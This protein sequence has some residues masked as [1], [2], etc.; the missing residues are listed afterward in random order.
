MKF[1]ISLLLVVSINS[2]AAPIEFVVRNSPGG[3]D[4]FITRKLMEHLEKN[5]NLQFI[6]TYKS[7]AAHAIAYRY[8][9]S[10]KKP[11]LII[12]DR[13]S[14]DYNQ[15]VMLT[16]EKIFTMGNFTNILFVRNGSGINSF[17]DLV[18]L[19]KERE[20]NFGHSGVGSFSLEGA[21]VICQ[22]IMS[23]LL[24][25]YRSGGPGMLDLAG[26]TID[27][28]AL[29]SYGSLGFL[30]NNLYRAI[31]VYSTQSHPALNVPVLTNQ[32][33]DLEL[34]NW[35]AIYGRNLSNEDQVSIQNALNKIDPQF[36]IENGFYK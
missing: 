33:K 8:F 6:A 28:Y 7:G 16:S 23:C 3:P 1:L 13:N 15:T 25:P 31:L 19:S 5:T 10:N 26:G 9:E 35:I 34:R 2:F 21:N 32:Y 30:D 29:A 11:M 36:F 4:D 18:K 27:A 17:D 14:L 20:I 22:K 24:V 12:A